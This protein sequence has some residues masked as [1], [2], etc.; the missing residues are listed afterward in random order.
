[1]SL[2]LNDKSRFFKFQAK[3]KPIPILKHSWEVNGTSL[4]TFGIL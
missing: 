4:F 3:K 2:I 1:M